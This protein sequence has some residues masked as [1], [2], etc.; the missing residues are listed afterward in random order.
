MK[1]RLPVSRTQTDLS[2][3]RCSIGII[4]AAACLML[5]TAVSVSMYGSYDFLPVIMSI[6]I[7]CILFL[8]IMIALPKRAVS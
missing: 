4:P 6:I 2:K 3:C 1:V 5:L 8:G 7:I